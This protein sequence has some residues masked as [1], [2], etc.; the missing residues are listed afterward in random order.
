[1]SDRSVTI[2][3]IQMTCTG[4]GAVEKAVKKV[5]EAAS[6]GAKIVCLPE[7]FSCP[8]FCQRKDD[9]SAFEKAEPIPGP[10]T[11]LLSQAAKEHGIVLIGG[12]VFEKTQSGK[13]YN[14]AVVF[15]RNG[16]LLDTY[17]KMHIPEDPRYHEQHYFSPGDSGVKVVDTPFGRIAVLICYDQWFPEV[18]RIAALSGAEIIFY[19]TA[20]GRF[21]DEAPEEGDWQDPWETVQRGHAIGN[22][23]YVAAVNRV[24]REDGL[25][26]WG[27]SFVCNEFG[28][29]IAHAGSQEE[30]L[31]AECDLSRIEQTRKAWGFLRNRRPELYKK[32]VQKTP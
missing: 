12:S 11:N 5:A 14:T 21:T 27:G 10:T 22:N 18:A 29:V 26:F 3:L 32:I 19:P 15:E 6:R 1:M 24:G 25:D 20:I 13:Y 30:I 28:S 2:G 16:S 9:T 17:R 4:A 31:I 8:Y 7:L 23:V